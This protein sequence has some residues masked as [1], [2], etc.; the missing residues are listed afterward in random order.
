MYKVFISNK[1][2]KQLNKIP[3][4][5]YLKIYSKMKSLEFNPRPNGCVKLTDTEDYRIRSGQYRILYTVNDKQSI[6]EIYNILDR[7]EA[8]KKK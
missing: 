7:K 1:A 5:Y 2:E 3:K 4:E 6:I 8:Y